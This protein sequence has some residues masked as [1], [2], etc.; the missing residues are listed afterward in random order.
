MA[1]SRPLRPTVAKPVPLE[2]HAM[3]N[4]RFI[5]ETME[6]ASSFTAVP[7]WGG[8]L[9]GLTALVS[10]FVA[11]R[12]PSPGRWLVVWMVAASVAL[13]I[14]SAATFRKAL[15][16]DTSLL[17]RPGRQFALSLAPPLLAGALLTLAL[18]R[19]GLVAVLPG[20]WLLLYGV[21]VVTSGTFSVRIVPAMGLCFMILGA[22]ALLAPAA[23]G[24]ALMAVGFGGLHLVFGGIIARRYGG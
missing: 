1:S 15:K 18:Y 7:G 12:Q 16:A 11:A 10:A 13:V 17:S 2:A 23:W 6:S 4:L 21:G 5:R 19:A 24:N 14:G 22:L 9:I 3:D 20:L 8:I